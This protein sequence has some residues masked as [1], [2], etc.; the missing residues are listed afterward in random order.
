M[1]E[2]ITQEQIQELLIEPN[3]EDFVES[4][5]ILSLLVLYET[6]MRRSELLALKESDIDFDHRYV[7]IIGKGK[8]ERIVPISQKLTELFRCY[9]DMKRAEIGEGFALLFCDGKGDAQNPRKFYQMV[10]S[11]LS[12]ISTVAARGP[13]ALRHAFATHLIDQGAELQ[14]VKDLLG[15][16]SLSSTQIYT[17]T[18][19]KRLREVYRKAH[20]RS[21][22]D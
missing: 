22:T 9:I 15:H 1:P 21:L 12:T 17:K 6:G 19:V 20:P 5:D 14:S 8:K 7:R 10:H 18:A 11:A 2:V 3:W 16:A 13:H 4:R